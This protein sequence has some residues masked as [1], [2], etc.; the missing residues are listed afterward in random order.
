[1]M[2]AIIGGIIFFFGAHQLVRFAEVTL[3]ARWRF[4][5]S[6]NNLLR[7]WLLFADD[8]S[9]LLKSIR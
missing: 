1:M 7:Q 2:D 6:V 4:F 8:Q 9:H 5:K 3:T